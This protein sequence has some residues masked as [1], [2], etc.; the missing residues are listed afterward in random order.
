MVGGMVARIHRFPSSSV[1]RNSLP[2]REPRKKLNARK[3]SPIAIVV[4]L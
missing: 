1:G 2:S 3:T 4:F